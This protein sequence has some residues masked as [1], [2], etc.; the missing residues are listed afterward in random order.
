MYSITLANGKQIKGLTLNGN[1]FISKTEVEGSLLTDETLSKIIIEKDNIKTI[2]YNVY[3]IQQSHYSN[4][5]YL[6]FAQRTPE[7]IQ[8]MES[9][10][11]IEYIAALTGVDLT[12]L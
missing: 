1:N 11:K 3:L 7:E 5:W 10:A 9:D 12:G 4:G 6:A 2:Y 8:K